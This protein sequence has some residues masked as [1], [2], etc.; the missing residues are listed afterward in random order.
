MVG[1]LAGWFGTNSLVGTIQRY[2]KNALLTCREVEVLS[3]N[4]NTSTVHLQQFAQPMLPLL[5]HDIA[6][7][8]NKLNVKN[9]EIQHASCLFQILQQFLE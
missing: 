8:T 5:Q 6:M 4:R 1:W 9:R 3:Y 7:E 2:Y